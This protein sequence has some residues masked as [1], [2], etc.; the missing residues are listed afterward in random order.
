MMLFHST[1]E[2]PLHTIGISGMDLVL[3]GSSHSFAIGDPSPEPGDQA[4][5]V[6][7][8]IRQMTFGCSN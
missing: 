7:E 6:E 5:R 2:R 1:H 3:F 8:T 4:Q